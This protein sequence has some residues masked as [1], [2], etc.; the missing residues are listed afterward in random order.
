M[1]IASWE[2]ERTISR[3]HKKAQDRR[4]KKNM[5]GKSEYEEECK[6]VKKGRNV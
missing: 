2:A 4:A 1:E 6:Q 3:L 5:Q